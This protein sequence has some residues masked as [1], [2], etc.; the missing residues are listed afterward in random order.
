MGGIYL[1]VFPYLGSDLV[2]LAQM[3]VD[4][5]YNAVS[6]VVEHWILSSASFVYRE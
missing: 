5:L 3:G 6:L 1:D 4:F 2:D